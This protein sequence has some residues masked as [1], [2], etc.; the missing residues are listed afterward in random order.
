VF[1]AS[2]GYTARPCLKK[3]QIIHIYVSFI[4]IYIYIY[5]SKGTHKRIYLKIMIFPLIELGYSFQKKCILLCSIPSQG[6]KCIPSVRECAT[7]RAGSILD[8]PSAVMGG[9]SLEIKKQTISVKY[10]RKFMS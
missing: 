10:N 6:P 1:E 2:L 8:F 4:Y 5:I 9:E 3:K 7:C